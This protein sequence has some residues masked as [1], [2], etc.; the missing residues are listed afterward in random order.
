MR[1]LI[2][3]LPDTRSVN[4]IGTSAIVPPARQTRRVISIWNP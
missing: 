3:D 2:F 1:R 4:V